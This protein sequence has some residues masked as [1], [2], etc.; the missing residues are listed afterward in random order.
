M[1]YKYNIVL[2]LAKFENP[3]PAFI[4]T[5]TGVYMQ[6]YPPLLITSLFT[7]GATPVKLRLYKLFAISMFLLLLLIVQ[8]TVITIA[9]KQVGM[10]TLLYYFAIVQHQY[11]IKIKQ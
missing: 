3:F 1:C 8:M 4:L 11:I 5:I 2:E 10:P 6:F 9:G 7:P